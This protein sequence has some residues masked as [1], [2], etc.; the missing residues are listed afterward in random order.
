[1]SEA[2]QAL[3][4][5]HIAEYDALAKQER[6]I[7]IDMVHFCG[8][9]LYQAFSIALDEKALSPAARLLYNNAERISLSANDIGYD[10]PEASQNRLAYVMLLDAVLVSPDVVMAAIKRIRDDLVAGDPKLALMK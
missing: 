3:I 2:T 1:M 6:H 5:R 10:H 4:A 8:D 9:S 7:A